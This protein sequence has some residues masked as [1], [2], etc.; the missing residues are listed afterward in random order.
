VAELFSVIRAQRACRRFDPDGEVSDSDIEEILDAAVHAPSAE[1]TQPWHFI[2]VRDAANREDLA[3][4]WTETWQAGGSEYARQA[5]TSDAMYADLEYAVGPGGF[6]SAPVVVVV[7]VDTQCVLEIFAQSS[8]YPAV[9]NMLLA[10]NALGYGSCL[11]TGLT[12]FGVER[13]RERLKLPDT[14]TPM[15][16]VYI[17]RPA[18]ALSPPRR[19]P[20]TEVTHRER[21]GIPW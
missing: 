3:R 5:V 12:T 16:A 19:R 15:A 14:V 9:Q 18:K 2:V 10:A 6:A 1:N 11:T 21:F 4:W 8:I 20:A 13:V 7:C 17:G